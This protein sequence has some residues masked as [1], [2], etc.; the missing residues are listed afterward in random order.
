[1][2]N[3]IDF[4]NV[5]MDR[6]VVAPIPYEH[7]KRLVGSRDGIVLNLGAG[8]KQIEGAVPLDLPEWDADVLPIPYGDESIAG[9]HAYHFLEHLRD[10]VRMLR[11]IER[12]LIVGGCC[13]VCVPYYSAQ[14]AAHDLDHKT[15]WCEDTW[16]I[17][18]QTPY[19]DKNRERS[20]QLRWRTNV[21]MGVAERNLVL[22]TQLQKV[23]Q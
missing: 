14:I 13:N 6:E 21:I 7:W 23:T 18:F 12:V 3:M 16:K 8:K 22:L 17:L 11:E 5:A 15:A 2:N 19:Y 1:M 10:P 20:W 4:F 9:I